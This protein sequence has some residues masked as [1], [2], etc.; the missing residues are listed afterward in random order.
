MQENHSF[1]SLTDNTVDNVI[2]IDIVREKTNSGGLCNCMFKHNERRAL[3]TD[4]LLTVTRQT[5][6]HIN[7]HML[8]SVSFTA[9]QGKNCNCFA[10]NFYFG[11]SPEPHR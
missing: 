4:A 2:T 11:Y 6:H 5:L 1:I 8:Y 9:I 7:K 3:D 10:Q